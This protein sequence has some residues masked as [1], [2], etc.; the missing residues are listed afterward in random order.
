MANRSKQKGTA[1]ESALVKYLTERGIEARRIVLHGSKDEGDVWTPTLSF[2]VKNCRTMAL[3][4]WVD[5]ATVEWINAGRPVVVCH[6][7]VGKG[8]PGD[9]YVTTTL[10]D[11]LGLTSPT[12]SDTLKEVER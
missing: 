2:E 11:F 12:Q 4:Q 5:E 10:D 7:R 3:A 9:W 6:K 1:A 8:S